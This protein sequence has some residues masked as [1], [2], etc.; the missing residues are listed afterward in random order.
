MTKTAAERAGIAAVRIRRRVARRAQCVRFYAL[1]GALC[2]L[3]E[4]DSEDDARYL[5]RDVRIEF[6][7][8]C[9]R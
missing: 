9:E 3:V 2:V 4:A 8:L 1:D 7:G 6:I 5:C